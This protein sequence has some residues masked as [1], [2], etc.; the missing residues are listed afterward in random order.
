MGKKC[1]YCINTVIH[2]GPLGSDESI[3]PAMHELGVLNSRECSNKGLCLSFWNTTSSR[4]AID[5]KFIYQHIFF[6]YLTSS[7]YP[8]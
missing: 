3:P 2:E 8:S 6:I 1:N 7:L 4:I 5:L